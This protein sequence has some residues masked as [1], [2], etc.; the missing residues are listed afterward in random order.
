M[1]KY[2]LPLIAAG[3][4]LA[5]QAVHAADGVV[6]RILEVSDTSITINAKEGK[7]TLPLN[8]STAVQTKDGGSGAVT[9]LKKG[10]IVK[11]IPGASDSDP[12][13]KVKVFKTE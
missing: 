10:Y 7:K 2:L 5:V 4:L 1:K 8:A 6:G 3:S 9:D 12:V 13:V 11:V